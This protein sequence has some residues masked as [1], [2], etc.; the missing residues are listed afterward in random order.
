MPPNNVMPEAIGRY[1]VKNPGY[2]EISVS[3]IPSSDTWYLNISGL[4]GLVEHGTL[5]LFITLPYGLYYYNVSTYYSGY[6]MFGYGTFQVEN[7]T[8]TFVLIVFTP[9]SGVKTPTQLPPPYPPELY[10]LIAEILILISGG[11]FILIRRL[12]TLSSET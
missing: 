11:L 9:K 12:R 1:V 10:A 2:V 3:G 5:S 7:N 6:A 4:S 8:G